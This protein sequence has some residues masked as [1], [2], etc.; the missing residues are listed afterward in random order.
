M[1]WEGEG[2]WAVLDGD[3]LLPVYERYGEG[4]AKPAVVLAG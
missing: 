4:R 3:E 2:P 1:D